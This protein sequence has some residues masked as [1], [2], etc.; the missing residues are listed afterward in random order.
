MEAAAAAKLRANDATAAALERLKADYARTQDEFAQA[1]AMTVAAARA[2]T[3]RALEV[4]AART[5]AELLA[6]QGECV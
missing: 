1:Q 6:L 2:D 3:G 4:A 5:Q